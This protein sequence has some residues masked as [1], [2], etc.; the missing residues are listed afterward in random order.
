MNRGRV[1]C[2]KLSAHYLI[3]SRNERNYYALNE[4]FYSLNSAMYKKVEDFSN[5]KNYFVTL[6]L[7]ITK[8]IKKKPINVSKPIHKTV[9]R[10]CKISSTGNIQK[11]TQLP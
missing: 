7:I 2:R 11:K 3:K 1:L 10:M 9:I 4:S 5:L 8:K 6:L